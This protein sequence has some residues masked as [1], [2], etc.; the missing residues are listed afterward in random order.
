MIGIACENVFVGWQDISAVHRD[1]GGDDPCS[2]RQQGV[3]DHDPAVID[4]NVIPG[5]ANHTLQQRNNSAACVG[6]GM[7]DMIIQSM[8]CYKILRQANQRQVA[9]N[10]P[11]AG[12]Y[13]PDQSVHGGCQVDAVVKHITGNQAAREY[14]RKPEAQGFN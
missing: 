5:H 8:P 12:I 4:S 13:F 7:G 10:G 11:G 1:C 3:I 2:V 14:R 6:N 9:M